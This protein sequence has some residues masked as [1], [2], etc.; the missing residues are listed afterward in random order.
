MRTSFSQSV[1]ASVFSPDDRL[2]EPRIT[3]E[4]SPQYRYVRHRM[5][6]DSG[7]PDEVMLCAHGS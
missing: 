1:I 4:R 3:L 6:D 7:H 5:V 2:S